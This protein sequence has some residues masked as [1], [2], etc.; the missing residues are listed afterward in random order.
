MSD[1][2][3]A[4]RTFRVWRLLVVVALAVLAWGV[5]VALRTRPLRPRE[6]GPRET[7]PVSLNAATY[8]EW[9][10]VP[11]ITPRL[12]RAIVAHRSANGPFRTVDDLE[13][14][15]GIGPKTLEKLKP[16]LQPP[17]ERAEK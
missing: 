9:L 1:P 11:G 16:Y 8:E 12:A 7:A 2:G 4:P 6:P 5:V 10:A 15:P 13:A 17:P 3:S 14:V